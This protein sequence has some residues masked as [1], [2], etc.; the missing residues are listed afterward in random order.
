MFRYLP[1]W[2]SGW[3]WRVLL[4][5]WGGEG[6]E[7]EEGERSVG[8]GGRSWMRGSRGGKRIS[9]MLLR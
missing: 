8:A 6:G 2:I 5:G 9:R 1:V 3:L 7:D 4:V